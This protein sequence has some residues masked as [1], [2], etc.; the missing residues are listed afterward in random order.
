MQKSYDATL[1]ATPQGKGVVV[2]GL[3]GTTAEDR[4]Y[5]L[6]NVKV[7]FTRRWVAGEQGAP[8]LVVPPGWRNGRR[9]GLKIPRV[10]PHLGSNPSPGIAAVTAYRGSAP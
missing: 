1:R 10:N 6:D 2:L 7:S 4:T 8:Y 5:H 9:R 3:W